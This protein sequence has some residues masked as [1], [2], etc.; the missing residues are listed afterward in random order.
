V[1]ISGSGRMA[2]VTFA[3]TSVSVVMQ[4]GGGGRGGGGGGVFES[5]GKNKGKV[6]GV[7]VV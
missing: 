2:L 4:S 6:V 5:A 1:V 7:L 3:M